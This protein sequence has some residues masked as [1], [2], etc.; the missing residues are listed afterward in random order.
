LKVFYTP[1]ANGAA[2][3]IIDISVN[4]IGMYCR[5]DR[6]EL[7]KLHPGLLEDDS[8]VVRLQ[9]ENCLRTEP[10]PCSE[11][12]WID[13]LECLPPVDWV[14]RGGGESFKMSERISGRMTKIFA[15][16]DSRCWSFVDTGDL[17]HFEI[18]NRV[19]LADQGEPVV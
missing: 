1:A 13:S 15:R 2:P 17:T 14:R 8:S 4:G 6:D 16:F 18:M 11:D 10:T 9:I 5:Q 19:K 12:E 7:S 3:Q